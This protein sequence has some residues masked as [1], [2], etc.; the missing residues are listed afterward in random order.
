[1]H[2][3]FE[4]TLDVTPQ[5]FDEIENDFKSSATKRS[6][7]LPTDFNS[8]SNGIKKIETFKNISFQLIIEIENDEK[9]RMTVIYKSSGPLPLTGYNSSWGNNSFILALKEDSKSIGFTGNLIEASNL[10]YNY[11]SP[12]LLDFK[13]SKVKISYNFSYPKRY[14]VGNRIEDLYIVDNNI[15]SI[16]IT[17]ISLTINTMSVKLNHLK[18]I[19]PF[20]YEG[21]LVF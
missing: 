1:M 15:N 14:Q 18:K 8:S 5:E 6:N 7:L 3:L 2:I 12:S 17:D 21:T 13:K 11:L 16:H 19:D 20:H 10:T 4:S 9:E